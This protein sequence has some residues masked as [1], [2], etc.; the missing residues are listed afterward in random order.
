MVV[1]FR[2]PRKVVRQCMINIVRRFLR[3]AARQPTAKSARKHPRKTVKLFM[4]KNAK[5]FLKTSAKMSRSDFSFL[6]WSFLL[7]RSALIF[8]VCKTTYEKKC[9]PSYNYGQTCENIPK[10]KCEYQKK[11]HTTYAE[12]CENIPKQKCSTSYEE[13]CKVKSIVL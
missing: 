12:S 5:K 2:F 4:R 7:T 9:K 6:I 1:C 10:Q 11:C 8:Q 3:R 13:H